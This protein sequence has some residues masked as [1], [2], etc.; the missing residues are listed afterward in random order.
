MWKKIILNSYRKALYPGRNQ[1]KNESG[2]KIPVNIIE[3][4]NVVIVPAKKSNNV[5]INT[6]HVSK[7][8]W[9]ITK[10]VLY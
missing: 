5:A 3:E 1:N 10:K 7:P 2:T 9:S 8:V 4:I 6:L